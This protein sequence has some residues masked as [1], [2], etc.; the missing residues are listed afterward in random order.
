MRV[1]QEN[2]TMKNKEENQDLRINTEHYLVTE[3]VDVE[4]L[5]KE[6]INDDLTLLTKAEE[7]MGAKSSP[8][9]GPNKN[10]QVQKAALAL[11]LKNPFKGF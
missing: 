11:K 5:E 2:K 10:P 3:A 1:T 6:K 8:C 9:E 4:S 7:K